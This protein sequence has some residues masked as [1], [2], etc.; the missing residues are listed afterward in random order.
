[1]EGAYNRHDHFDER[2]RALEAWGQLM[3][4]LERGD[5]TAKAGTAKAA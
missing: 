3:L 4:K 1:M 2:R 5:A